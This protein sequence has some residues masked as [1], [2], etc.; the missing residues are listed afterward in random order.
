MPNIQFMI[1]AINETR[2]PFA[3]A[4]SDLEALHK[5][6]LEGRNSVGELR[7]AES[8]LT[9]A[10]RYQYEAY[11]DLFGTMRQVGAIG[12][13][14]LNISNARNL[15]EIR[16]ADA[17]KNVADAQAAANVALEIYGSQSVQYQAA[18][19]SLK[20]AQ[21]GL[22]K[23]TDDANAAGVSM[24][25]SLVGVA[26]NVGTLGLRIGEAITK[27]GGLSAALTGL[28]GFDTIAIPVAITV[29]GL[30]ALI[31]AN[32]IINQQRQTPDV[33]TDEG[34][35]LLQQQADHGIYTG[36]V[37]DALGGSGTYTGRNNGLPS[38]GFNFLDAGA[39]PPIVSPSAGPDYGDP[40]YW[41]NPRGGAGYGSRGP[42]GATITVNNYV[43][44]IS[45]QA[46]ADNL[47]AYV[48]KLI[49][50]RSRESN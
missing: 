28:A 3:E 7:R 32:N 24:G 2:G 34:R 23:A 41:F 16:L 10:Y 9:Q 12:N 5:A 48:D 14:L 42:V 30:T 40:N 45:N 43:D 8:Y 6:R 44:K 31:E 35:K 39:V 46:D 25:L 20:A 13:Q 29:T 4:Q 50:D 22:K 21:E 37:L 19:D 15:S 33:S 49:R 38:S 17:T 11:Y 1:Q 26:S 36:S 27:A 18:L 47:A